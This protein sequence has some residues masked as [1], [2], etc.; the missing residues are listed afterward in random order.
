V[1]QSWSS[2]LSLPTPMVMRKARDVTYTLDEIR[3][4]GKG[5][6]AVISSSYSLADSVPRN[7]PIP[8]TGSFNMSGTFG[9]FR[10]YQILSLKGQGED[11]FNIDAGRIEQ[12]NQYY[13]MHL[14]AALP[15]PIGASPEITI[16]QRITMQLLK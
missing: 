1:G 3:Q 9:F 16:K 6:L 8:Y 5:R 10:G 12:Y 13:R 15:G 7:W 2:K 14:S 4:S 11:L